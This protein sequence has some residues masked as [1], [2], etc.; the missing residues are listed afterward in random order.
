ME[1]FENLLYCTTC[2]QHYYYTG[3]HVRITAVIRA[4]WLCQKCKWC[5]N[6]RKSSQ[7][8]RYLLCDVCDG[9]FHAHCLRPPITTIPKN[10]WK[11]KRCRKCTDCGAKVPGSG[12]SSRWHANYS[13]CDSCYQQRNKGLAC[14]ICGRAYRHSAQKDMLQCNLCKRHIHGQCDFEALEQS[15]KRTNFMYVCKPCKTGNPGRSHNPSGGSANSGSS[16]IHAA[17]KDDP[18]WCESDSL[19]S[20]D[21]F[22]GGGS[23]R[24]GKPMMS[25]LSQGKDQAKM[26]RKRLNPAL[27]RRGGLKGNSNYSSSGTL[28]NNAGFVGEGATTA[29]AAL[30]SKKRGEARRRGRQTTKLRGMVGLQVRSSSYYCGEKSIAKNA[31]ADELAKLCQLISAKSSYLKY[32]I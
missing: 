14:P 24:G 22:Y 23:G 8:D 10:G 26:Q 11:C 29:A 25:A 3:A 28:M 27:H 18:D 17:I 20:S 5:L 16:P 9:A 32:H 13:V 2:G 19:D 30:A 12:Q 6:C 21:R 7:D 4:G 15:E 31:L 1:K